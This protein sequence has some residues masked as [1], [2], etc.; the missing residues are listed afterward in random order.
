MLDQVIVAFESEKTCRRLK[1]ILESSGTASCLICRSGDQVRRWVNKRHI[2]VV[3]CGYK[4]AE[5]SAVDVL[6]DLPA[7]CSMLL[8]ARQDLLDLVRGDK[9]F[10]LPAPVSRGVLIE[11]VGR[12]LRAGGDSEDSFLQRSREEQRLIAQAKGIL[13]ERCGLTE[14]TAHRF[15]QKKSMD[16][17][18]K[19]VRTAEMVLEE[20]A[21]A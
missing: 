10:P 1:E 3:I 20:Y 14:E 13:M 17:G 21:D 4:L 5:E 6:S 18:E 19:L 2:T 9:L 7:F 8:L 15:L 12:L 11:T 16:R